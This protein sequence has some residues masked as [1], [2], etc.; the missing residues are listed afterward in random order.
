M[1]QGLGMLRCSMEQA[2]STPVSHAPSEPPCSYPR[3]DEQNPGR[4]MN[5]QEGFSIS[6]GWL[7]LTQLGTMVVWVLSLVPVLCLMCRS[8]ASSCSMLPVA[9]ICRCYRMVGLEGTLRTVETQNGW[10]GRDLKPPSSTPCCRLGA[11]HQTRAP[12]NLTLGIFR[13]WAQA[14]IQAADY[15]NPSHHSI[16][17]MDHVLSLPALAAPGVGGWISPSQT[18]GG[19][20][21]SH[22]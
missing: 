18:S 19:E 17:L 2:L 16:A 4:A 9:D 13:H 1:V 8:S 6:W 10:V 22:C 12:F 7:M 11:P 21:H 3:V 14:K 20:K 5:S 15:P